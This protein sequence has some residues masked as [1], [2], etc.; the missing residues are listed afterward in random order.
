M[1]QEMAGAPWRVA[2]TRDDDRDGAVARALEEAGF[3]AVS[4]PVLVEGPAPDQVALRSAAVNLE[5]YDWIVC[6]SVRAVRALVS[7]RGSSWPKGPRTAA[8][9]A[10]TAQAMR[11]AG[12]AQPIVGSAFN[13]KALW[14][15]LRPLDAWSGRRV[16][17]ATVPGGRR[18]V[19]DG[20]RREG[21]E[22][23]ELNAYTMVARVVDD[24]RH[25]WAV[26]HPDAVIVGSAAI[27]RHLIDA[28]GVE[29]ILEL[30]AIVP[31]GPTTAEALR[32]AGVGANPPRQATFT[33]AVAHLASIACVD[34]ARRAEPELDARAK[35]ESSEVG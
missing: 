16:L 29:A 5:R 22:V 28:I 4:C 7:A 30:K 12:A 9:G 27:A 13:A 19:I 31:I 21:A 34:D 18:D 24:V 26:A 20:L 23:T 6:A 3:V 11:D 8:V 17:I 25:D 10:V 1:L 33:A 2:V 35:V 15:T 14:E 32:S